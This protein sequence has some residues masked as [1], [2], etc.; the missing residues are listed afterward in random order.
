MLISK[1]IEHP[2]IIFLYIVINMKNLIDSVL[3]NYDL[4]TCISFYSLSQG[5]A[6]ENYK[7]TT[8]KGHFLFRICKEQTLEMIHYE[9]RLMEAL[10]TIDF[11][12][13]FPIKR[14][15][16]KYITKSS[17]GNIVLY[18]F[19]PG[20]EPELEPNVVCEIASALAKLSLLP[21]PEKF[22]K[23]N[24]VNLPDCLK[25]IENFPNVKYQ[26]PQIFH[27]FENIIKFLHDPLSIDLPKGVIHA[28]IFPDNT[29]FQ[30]E[31]LI[32]IIDFEEANYDN[33]LFD[34][35]MTINGFCF[36]NN[37]LDEDL[38]K[39]FISTYNKIRPLTQQEKDLVYYYILWGAVGM[40]YWHLRHLVNR[41]YITQKN[42]VE[43]LIN[44]VKII[45]N[46]KKTQNIFISNN[47]V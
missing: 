11:P 42:R 30:N 20:N 40:A 43:E 23:Q 22:L 14:T 2:I 27:D 16:N 1:E 18:E 29:L 34:V 35:G 32:A 31:K 15:D 44:R 13:A 3:L 8:N 5:F 38:F 33:L 6:N 12:T 47:L 25:M 7:I 4:G 46:S 36:R 37:L 9:M 45:Q 39:N 17:V 26:Y 24:V 21:S 10:K 19:K 41:P 28:D